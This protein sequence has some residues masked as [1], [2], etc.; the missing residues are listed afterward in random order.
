M[1]EAVLELRKVSGTMKKMGKQAK[2]KKP[3]PLSLGPVSSSVFDMAPTSP[4]SAARAKKRKRPDGPLVQIPPS[5]SQQFPSH[6]GFSTPTANKNQANTPRSQRAVFS[7]Y[8]PM[9]STPV[10][11]GAIPDSCIARNI[12]RE[13]SSGCFLRS[14]LISNTLSVSCLSFFFS[15]LVAAD[16]TN[17]KLAPCSATQTA[18][19]GSGCVQ[20]EQAQ[21]V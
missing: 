10:N 16:A 18:R 4:N 3:K 11:P 15:W 13:R 14:S 20:S 6:S 17:T 5:S 9:T 1:A 12:I 19:T 2:P 7:A 21:A 8:T